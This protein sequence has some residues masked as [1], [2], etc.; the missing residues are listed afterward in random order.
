MRVV[1][2][3]E[4]TFETG[5]GGPFDTGV[6]LTGK[7]VILIHT[8]YGG[9]NIDI[10]GDNHFKITDK[11]KITPLFFVDIGSKIKVLVSETVSIPANVD[12]KDLRR[13][14]SNVPN[15]VVDTDRFAV[16]GDDMHQFA[17][18][19]EFYDA[20][21]GSNVFTVHLGFVPTAGDPLVVSISDGYGIEI[22]NQTFDILNSE[23][24]QKVS[25]VFSVPFQHDLGSHVSFGMVLKGIFKEKAVYFCEKDDAPNFR[26]FTN[27][28]KVQRRNFFD[29]SRG[30]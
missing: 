18:H 20:L 4:Y 16:T 22:F 13:K 30:Y 3:H 14:F 11:S 17:I 6:D 1:Y 5:Q 25:R 19:N 9:Y 12:V 29:Q 26:H 21:V 8:R 27:F 23:I 2:E 7:D 28:E 24:N 15:V 10:E